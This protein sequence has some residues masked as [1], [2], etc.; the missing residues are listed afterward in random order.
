MKHV[1]WWLT[2]IKYF[3]AAVIYCGVNN[4]LYMSR[5][6]FLR[7]STLFLSIE[8]MGTRTGYTA[9]FFCRC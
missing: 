4:K 5:T 6:H 7:I 3:L 9:D 2:F 8:A 1:V